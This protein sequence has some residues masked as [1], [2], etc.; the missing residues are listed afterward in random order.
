M[1]LTQQV[2][3]H[4]GFAN[5]LSEYDA[6]VNMDR[7]TS[8]SECSTSYSIVTLPVIRRSDHR[9]PASGCYDLLS[10]ELHPVDAAASSSASRRHRKHC[11][12]HKLR[13]GGLDAAM[14]DLAPV[15][16]P[17]PSLAYLLSH[18]PLAALSLVPKAAVL[19]L[20]GA[21]SGGL[22]ALCRHQC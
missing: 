6:A 12:R 22:G 8:S 16:A 9:H 4:R 3:G 7:L 17:A 15:D 21:V 1:Q 2:S 11:R 18:R 10:F 5:G 20:A 14:V 13:G 19:F